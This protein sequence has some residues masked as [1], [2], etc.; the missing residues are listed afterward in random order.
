M[1]DCKWV[2]WKGE[3]EEHWGRKSSRRCTLQIT[4]GSSCINPP[5]GTALKAN[6]AVFPNV[7]LLPSVVWSLFTVSAAN[8]TIVIYNRWW[9]HLYHLLAHYPDAQAHDSATQSSMGA[10]PGW[11]KVD[12]PGP[13]SPSTVSVVD[14]TKICS[15]SRSSF[16]I[17]A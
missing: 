11:D 9:K 12:K 2:P 14:K 10:S 13:G 6:V 7:G 8:N 1:A 3:A 4:A 5:G 15:G 17:S 16:S